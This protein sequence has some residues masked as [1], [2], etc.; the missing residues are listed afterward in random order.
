MLFAKLP[1]NRPPKGT[2][3]INAIMP[4]YKNSTPGPVCPP[5]QWSAKPCYSMPF[6]GEG[7]R[8]PEGQNEYNK[9]LTKQLRIDLEIA[10]CHVMCREETRRYFGIKGPAV[11]EVIK[12]DRGKVVLPF[13]CFSQSPY[14]PILLFN[15]KFDPEGR[16]LSHLTFYFDISIVALND[17]VTDG[18]SQPR[19]F[20]SLFG[21]EEGGKEFGE[22]FFCHTTPCIGE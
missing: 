10:S 18:Q 1:A 13:L 15:G 2:V 8:R 22:M 5:R 6:E 17:S 16:S 7:P 11:G 12:G 3:F 20:A 19:S 21:R 9:G 14:L 4:S